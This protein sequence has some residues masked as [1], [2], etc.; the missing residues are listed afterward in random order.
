VVNG[1]GRQP[2]V[3]EISSWGWISWIGLG[4]AGVGRV[5]AERTEGVLYA[6]GPAV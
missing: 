4:R 1:L 5:T 2:T 6:Q 3:R